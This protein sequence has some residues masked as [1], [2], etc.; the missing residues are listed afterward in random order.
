MKTQNSK[1]SKKNQVGNRKAGSRIN[2]IERMEHPPQLNSYQVVHNTTLRFTVTAAVVNFGVT[3]EMLLDALLIADTAI[4]G[5]QLFDSFKLRFIEI[6]GQAALGTPSTVELQFPEATGDTRVVTDTSLG[7]KPAYLK[8]GPSRLSLASFWQ[9]TSGNVLVDITAGSGSII[10]VHL[11]Y[12]TSTAAPVALANALVGAN[13]GEFYFR[14]L[15]GLA[16][17]ATNFPPPIGVNTR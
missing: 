6:W 14:G 7:I 3:P 16:I 15:D 2:M 1:K 4:H 12:R 10:D 9:I 5:F 13:P 17:A 11:T 8:A